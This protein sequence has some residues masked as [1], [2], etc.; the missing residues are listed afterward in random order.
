VRHRQGYST[1]KARDDETDRI[2]AAATLGYA[3][4][5]LGI[6]LQV[7]PQEARSDGNFLVPVK[8]EIPIGNLA[9]LPQK[10]RHM[11]QISMR[12]VVCDDQGRLSDVHDRAYPFEIANDQLVSAITQEAS[13][14]LGMVLR[15]GTQRVAVSIQDTNSLVESTAFV[16]VEVGPDPTDRSK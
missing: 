8:I 14:V 5:P 6:T 2:L 15:K 7:Q 1:E 11:A 9:L 16:D 3:K 12:S 13:F 10:D 4:N